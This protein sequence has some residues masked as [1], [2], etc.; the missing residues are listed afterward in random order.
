MNE[1]LRRAAPGL[2]L[3]GVALSTVWLFD[4]A[5]QAARARSEPV[6][7]GG[8]SSAEA[9]EPSRSDSAAGTPETTSPETTSPGTTTEQPASSDCGDPTAVTGDAAMTR[10]GQVQVQMEFAPDGTVCSVTAIAYP[11]GD[12]HSAELNSRAV[13]YLDAQAA[14]SGVEFDSFTGA[15]YTSQA[16]RESMQSILDQR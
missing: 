10:W 15:T 12:H 3:A 11:D 4:P 5:L 8:D 1:L 6:P 16:Y 14:Q 7:A 2:A 13:P 9:T